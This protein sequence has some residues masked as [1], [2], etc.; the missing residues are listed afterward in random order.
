MKRITASVSL[1]VL[2]VVAAP[3][4]AQQTPPQQPEMPVFAET[5]DVR[6]INLD[7]VVTDKKGNAIK[8]LKAEDFF[9]VEN[10]REQKITN[11]YEVSDRQATV[12]GK[13]AD[14]A[15]PAAPPIQPREERPEH[16][17]RRIVIF[18]D[19][20]SLAPFN[21]NRVFGQMKEFVRT[22]LRPGDEAMIATWNRSMKVRV[23]FTSDR[24]Q[25]EQ[26]LDAIEGESAYG[27]QHMSERRDVESRIRDAQ[28]YTDAVGYARGYAQSVE[29][30]LRQT[31]SAVNGLIST[32]AGVEGKKIMLLTSEGFP[33]QPGREM[34]HYIDEMKRQKREWAHAGSS[35]L[36]GMSFDSTTV[37]QSIARAA[38]ANGITLYALHAGGLMG[39]N[40]GSAEHAAPI[41]VAVEQA[42]L[43]NSTDSLTLLAQMTGG[44]ATVGTNNFKSAFERIAQDLASYYSI[45][46]RSA[47]ERV[48][49]QRSVEVRARNRG[50]VVRARKT[51]V[52]KSIPTEMTD[53]VVANLFYPSN[54]ND[55]KIFLTTGR[56]VQV[57]SDRFRVPVEVHIPME[58]LTLIP[59]GEIMAGGFAVYVVAAD[60]EGDMSDVSQQS[61]A[62]RIP[63]SEIS[64]VP[65]KH[66]TWSVELLMKKGRN[67]I[68]VGLIDEISRVTGFQR[69]EV[70]AADLR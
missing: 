24:T 20:L 29:H 8:G 16:L 6:V 5:V 21:R 2:A 31:A 26:A 56:P 61:H 60:L 37:I 11:F 4:Y 55:M 17:R 57:E 70:L 52:E 40:E 58:S 45:G 22:S 47:T 68:S 51:F 9:V 3:L 64:K 48:D 33:M 28:S 27:L 34:F 53:R 1:I 38:N 66:Y 36:E 43:S 7:V 10:G 63:T 30:D 23:P 67:K 41:P 59:Q 49:R 13:P 39:Y 14:E 42:A 65:G 46:Y 69:Q 19:N 44:Q 54:S 25:I 35:L 18:V 62:I 15:T 50:Y 32:L 12:E